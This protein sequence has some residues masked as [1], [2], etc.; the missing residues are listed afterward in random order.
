MKRLLI[1]IFIFCSL[2][3]GSQEAFA[4]D[5]SKIS[6]NTKITK[7][8]DSLYSIN[9]RDVIAILYGRNATKKPIR[10]MFRDLSVY[11]FSDCEALT[12]K[13]KSN[14]LVIYI[15]NEHRGAS[16]ECIACLI[17]HESQH[18]TFTNS[19]AEE[20]RAW[21]SESQAWNEFTK[22]NKAL[23]M[24]NEPLAKRENYIANLRAKSGVQGVQKLI[25]NNPVYAGLN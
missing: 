18:H 11:G 9:R 13:T 12:V 23:A 8:L 20:L 6:T 22:R 3:L 2:F 21:I 16:P 10:V 25:A 24:S 19:K 17:A 1:A 14:G 4:L 7:A 5:Y 15:S